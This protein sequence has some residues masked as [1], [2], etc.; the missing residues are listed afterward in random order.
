MLLI[1]QILA[2]IV[3]FYVVGDF[4]VHAMREDSGLSSEFIDCDKKYSDDYD[5]SLDGTKSDSTVSFKNKNSVKSE[6]LKN[7]AKTD[8]VCVQ[9]DKHTK[10]ENVV[11]S[12]VDSDEDEQKNDNDSTFKNVC[13]AINPFRDVYYDACREYDRIKTAD[14][15]KKA[16]EKSKRKY[17]NNN[18]FDGKD[19]TV[20]T[21]DL[22]IYSDGDFDLN[23][24]LLFGYNFQKYK[25]S[26]D[27]L[28][29]EKNVAIKF[30]K[31]ES[32][33]NSDKASLIKKMI[34]FPV[35]S[36]LLM[37]LIGV[38]IFSCPSYSLYNL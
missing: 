2:L 28:I 18:M 9:Y 26:F 8:H 6:K 17:P 20:I 15:E 5:V 25:T 30:F 29:Q 3:N 10:D 1:R 19:E 32:D 34:Y 36:F 12:D 11:Y 14:P 23:F 35:K 31:N 13:K 4:K 38:N 33:Y 27:R 24:D 21:D 7:Q 37:I 22:K 16:E